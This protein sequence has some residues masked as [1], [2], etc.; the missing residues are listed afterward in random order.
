MSRC[1]VPRSILSLTLTLSVLP[2]PWTVVNRW[3]PLL[4]RQS[5][6]WVTLATR[7]VHLARGRLRTALLLVLVTIPRC[8]Q[9]PVIPAMPEL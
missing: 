7:R 2:V 3:F 9:A 5:T 6:N 1:V 8:R 4:S